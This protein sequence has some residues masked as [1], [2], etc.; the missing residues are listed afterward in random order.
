MEPRHRDHERL[1]HNRERAMDLQ[2]IDSLHVT[3]AERLGS[4]LDAG[5]PVP[6]NERLRDEQKVPVA[7]ARGEPIKTPAGGLLLCAR[8]LEMSPD[9]LP[10]NGIPPSHSSGGCRQRGPSPRRNH[11][12]PWSSPVGGTGRLLCAQVASQASQP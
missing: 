2:V 11:E 4:V 10:H 1:I 7:R 9:R 5:A 3:T 12:C 8:S 6:D